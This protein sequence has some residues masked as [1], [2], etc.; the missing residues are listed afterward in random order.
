MMN[1]L[2]QNSWIE[3]C[4]KNTHNFDK[5]WQKILLAAFVGGS[6][7]CMSVSAQTSNFPKVKTVETKPATTSNLNDSYQD[8][9]KLGP[10]I[11][12]SQVSI[13]QK[14]F[15]S[16]V[17][18]LTKL[19]LEQAIEISLERNPSLSS[20]QWQIEQ[21][22]ALEQSASSALNPTISLK[23]IGSYS[24]TASAK[25]TNAAIAPLRTN[26]LTTSQVESTLTTP[27][28][29]GQPT[30]SQSQ[31][32]LLAP[33]IVNTNNNIADAFNISLGN[34]FTAT[35]NLGINWFFYTS[36]RVENSILS[37]SKN[38]EAAYFEYR[39]AKI[40]LIYQVIIAYTNVQLAYGTVQINQANVD[41]A[42]QLLYDNQEKQKVG[43][44][45][46]VDVLQS[47]SQ[48]ASAYQD[49]TAAKN[50]LQ[51]QR[52][53]LSQ[54]LSL[55]GPQP[56]EAVDQIAPMGQWK[57][58][59]EETILKAF[60][61]RP[62]LKQ[63]SA[64]EE[65]AKASEAQAYSSVAPQMSLFANLQALTGSKT[66][67][68]FTGYNVGVQVQWDAYDGGMVEGQAKAERAKA[69]Q[70]RLSFAAALDQI[71]FD[72]Q[73]SMLNLQTAKQQIETTNL[74]LKAATESNRSML[75]YYS[76]GLAS[77]TE[78]ILNQQSLVKAQISQL[79][80]IIDYNQA[81]A[82]IH[83][84]VGMLSDETNSKF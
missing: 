4:R 72:V 48:L 5:I 54:I 41:T 7:F 34:D 39:N 19:S 83:R 74:G 45:T 30:F 76:Q 79:T 70:S 15:G 81:L 61:Q 6:Q 31:A 67:G 69:Y 8:S 2:N 59:V 16:N 63:N 3:R 37:A 57:L 28:A 75:L 21:N 49:L 36:G 82:K 42:K 24:D 50:T 22:K 58:S 44:A 12:P 47:K 51:I 27:D 77:T 23:I 9:S 62:E 13:P 33:F 29:N 52:A 56:L 10:A 26:S 38:T 66:G 40:Q 18:K 32:N 25:A 60:Q 64:L 14:P 1:K 73:S 80:A 46:S 84:S 65:A 71:R 68:T 55:D 78:V 53:L 35:G 43:Y 11:V 20:S 17:Q